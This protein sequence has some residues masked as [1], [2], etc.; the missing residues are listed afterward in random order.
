MIYAAMNGNKH[1]VEMLLDLG[2]DPKKVDETGRE[3]L[4]WAEE[5]RRVQVVDI[6]RKSREDQV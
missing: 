6:L 3:A 1:A 4:R 2:A 5:N